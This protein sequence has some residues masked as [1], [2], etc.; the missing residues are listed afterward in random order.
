MTPPPPPSR[1]QTVAFMAL[2]RALTAPAQPEETLPQGDCA[3]P[4]AGT[5]LRHCDLAGAALAGID[6]SDTR[7]DGVRLEN[8]NLSGAKLV[9]ARFQGANL[10]WANLADADLSAAALQGANLFHATL[11]GAL[12]DGAQFANANLFG[13]N[14]IETRARGADF[15]DAHM[16]DLLAE[17]ADFTGSRLDR[18]FIFRGVLIDSRLTGASLRQVVLTGASLEGAD[19]SGA[20]LSGSLLNGAHLAGSSFRGARLTGALPQCPGPGSG[21]CRHP[22]DPGALGG[23]SGQ[24][25]RCG[26]PTRSARRRGRSQNNPGRCPELICVI[27]LGSSRKMGGNGVP[28]S[29]S[30]P[31]LNADI[32]FPNRARGDWGWHRSP[33]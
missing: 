18:A 22:G 20:D 16:K 13:A 26:P 27:P 21:F 7:L 6:L 5:D 10:Q 23:E 9:R 28:G 19:L 32:A 8:A 33:P 31:T 17:G 1:T 30:G 2:S 12:A 29:C 4:R 3:A 14:L 15:S 11:D 24:M 25:T